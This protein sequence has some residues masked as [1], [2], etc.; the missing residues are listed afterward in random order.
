MSLFNRFLR[1]GVIAA[2]G[3][4]LC[5]LS[6]VAGASLH[7]S[8][9]LA[10]QF[11]LPATVVG[12]TAAVVA[13]IC[14]WVRIAGVAVIATVVA[15][16]VAMPWVATPAPVPRE[17]TRF[18]LLLFNV[19][20]NNG[21]LEDVRRMVERSN[22]DVVV[23]VEITPR[24]RD[25]MQSLNKTYPYKFDCTGAGRCDIMIFSRSR[26]LPREIK[27]TSDPDRSPLVSA[28]TDLG[29]CA[30][31]LFATH[32]TRPFPNR[33]YWAQ[34]AQAEEIGSDVA[35]PSG[36]KLVVGDF[37]AAPWGYVM[38]TIAKRGGVNVL[39]GAGGTWPSTLPP[40]LRIPIDNVL[41]SPGLSFVSRQVLPKLGSDHLP[42]LAEIAV[43]DH[44]A[45][46]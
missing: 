45:C 35:A 37:N 17:A 21:R 39:T 12:A 18:T 10:A 11:L 2:L 38:Q 20:F 34:R 42:V 26:L 30:L 15:F 13:L 28:E 40:Q 3:W 1:A 36:A 7:W 14:G 19:W 29:G 8:F 16:V 5:V 41:A 23:L 44:S 46:R 33:P 43:T 6:G 25:A 9:D 24:I 4:T 31:T 27:E 32:M 22:A